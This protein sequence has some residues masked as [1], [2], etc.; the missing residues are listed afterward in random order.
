MDHLLEVDL[1]VESN[2]ISDSSYKGSV[3]IP[4][5]TFN[6]YVNQSN[7]KLLKNV[8][9]ERLSFENFAFHFPRKNP[10]FESFSEKIPYLL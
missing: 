10:Y 6:D 4:A 3:H 9:K 7:G 5:Q 8:L 2:N 1:L